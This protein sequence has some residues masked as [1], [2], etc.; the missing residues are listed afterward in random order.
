[1]L[2]TYGE[3]MHGGQGTTN[4]IRLGWSL[5]KVLTRDEATWVGKT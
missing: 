3:R 2:Q 4:Q 5:K 1:M